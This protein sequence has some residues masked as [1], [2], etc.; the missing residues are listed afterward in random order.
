VGRSVDKKTGMPH[1]TCKA[2]LTAGK[3][4]AKLI[5]IHKRKERALEKQGMQV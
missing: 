4:L 1:E 2:L 5:S 3:E